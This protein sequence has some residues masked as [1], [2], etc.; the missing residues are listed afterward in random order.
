MN[1][2]NGRPVEDSDWKVW[3]RN[4]IE[5]HESALVRYAQH[6]VGDLE[7]GR[8]VVQ[9]TFLKLCHQPREKLENEI[10]PILVKWLFK[11]CRN[12]AIDVCRKENRMKLAPT[13]QLAEQLADS[14]NE[15]H[16]RSSA[17]EAAAQSKEQTDTLGKQISRLP[18]NQQEVL[19]LKFH[20]GMSYREIAEITGLTTSNVGFLLHTAIAK[21]RQRVVTSAE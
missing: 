15:F 7:R 13:D 9:D 11:V 8:D 6:F 17:P 1:E 5:Q 10:Q 18:N 12:R 20:G 4:A 3:I 19:R 2:S 21:L 14:E 16:Q